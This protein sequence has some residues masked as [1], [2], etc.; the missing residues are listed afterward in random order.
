[1]IIGIAGRYRSGKTELAK[2]CQEHG[3]EKL[4]FALPLKN[5]CAELLGVTI[6]EL[7]RMKDDGTDTGFV[8]NG[9]A[10]HKIS[11]KTDIPLELVINAGL[12][13]ELPTVRSMLQF[14]GT[15][16]IR[17]YNTDWHV[18]EIRKMID[19]EKDYVLDDVRFPNEKRMIESLGGDVWFVVR[20]TLSNISYHKSETSLTWRDCWNKVI[21]N[22]RT[23]EDLKFRWSTFIADYAHSSELREKL[24]RKAL[25][26]PKKGYSEEV[27]PLESLFL[28]DEMFEARLT[29]NDPCFNEDDIVS[30]TQAPHGTV[31]IRRSNN[32]SEVIA[33]PLTIEDI[34]M[35][36]YFKK[37]GNHFDINDNLD[38]FEEKEYG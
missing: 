38:I 11:E 24:Y 8:M 37:H 4:Y 15:D 3:Y 27:S 20:P 9:K 18:S 31:V 34:K 22:D 35:L 19:P 6:D 36:N 33:N 16:L 30:I 25:E 26:S 21:I 14:I 28:P 7:N 1:M 29:D 10:C 13:L 17:R 32:V 23:L 12:G 5:I 2:V